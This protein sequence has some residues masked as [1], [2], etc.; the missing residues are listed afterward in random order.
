MKYLIPLAFVVVPALALAQPAA[1]VPAPA[2]LQV[3]GAATVSQLPDRV[4]I[5]IGV[6]TQSSH[7]QTAAQSNASRVSKV[8]AALRAAAGPG[9]VL[10]T[11]NYAIQPRY[12]Y[13]NDG[14]PP[15]LT[16]YTVSN[17]VRV[18]LDTLQR[19]GRVIDAA[20]ATGANLQQNL[21]F[22]LRDPEAVRLRALA[23]AAVRARH[24]AE[25]L[26]AALDLRIIRIVSVRQIGGSAMPPTPR[27]YA[28]AIRAQ[29]VS[30]PIQSGR[31]DVTVRVTLT[32]AVARKSE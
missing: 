29:R 23:R 32:V 19:I 10:T 6:T 30:T 16:G 1:R 3:T 4:Y 26:A 18:Q 8:L 21:R 13:H 22:A 5:D 12:R 9:A 24:A 11:I 17:V 15:T 2:T 20:S 27:I 25:T 14:T 7:P 28:M 31:I